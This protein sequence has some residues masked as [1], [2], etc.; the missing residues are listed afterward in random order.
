MNSRSSVEDFDDEDPTS[1]GQ[2]REKFRITPKIDYII[3]FLDKTKNGSRYLRFA[4]SFATQQ[5]NSPETDPAFKKFSNSIAGNIVK[6]F[7]DSLSQETQKKQN[8]I[9]IH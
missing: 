2:D 7:I 9:T 1:F 8:S 6:K 5:K 4:H 3:E